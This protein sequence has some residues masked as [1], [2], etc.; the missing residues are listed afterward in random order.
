MMFS[1]ATGEEGEEQLLSRTALFEVVS[2]SVHRARVRP[3]V[4]LLPAVGP[5][6]DAAE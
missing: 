3:R 5:G 1:P 6:H 4:A 2:L